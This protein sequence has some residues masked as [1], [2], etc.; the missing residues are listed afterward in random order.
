MIWHF[1]RQSIPHDV[2]SGYPNPDSWPAPNAF[3]SADNCAVDSSFSPQSFVLD[4][5]ICGGWATGDYPN[6][7]CPGTCSQRVTRG[8]N[9]V[10]AYFMVY[11]LSC[12]SC[13][14]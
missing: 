6:S 5:A 4:I 14:W 3:L 9:Y 1:E 13:K 7:D 8:R 12:L 11:G 2:Y 10:G